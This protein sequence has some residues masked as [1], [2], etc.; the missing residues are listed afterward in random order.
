MQEFSWTT[1]EISWNPAVDFPDH[2]LWSG[3]CHLKFMSCL[4]LMAEVGRKGRVKTYCH[5]CTFRWRELLRTQDEACFACL[6]GR[7]LYHGI[8]AQVYLN[9]YFTFLWYAYNERNACLSSSTCI[10][11]SSSCGLKRVFPNII[12]CLLFIEVWWSD[13]PGVDVSPS[14]WSF[15]YYFCSYCKTISLPLLWFIPKCSQCTPM[16]QLA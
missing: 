14:Q 16:S 4:L 7:F 15:L 10:F 13:C 2:L 12:C 8:F 11:T 6:Q 3:K 9:F 5:A 1:C